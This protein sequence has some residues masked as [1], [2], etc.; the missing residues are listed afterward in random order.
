MLPYN[1]KSCFFNMKICFATFLALLPLATTAALAQEPAVKDSKGFYGTIGLGFS[2]PQDLTASGDSKLGIP[3]NADIKLGGG[4]AGEAG[5]GY[6]FGLVR[7]ELTYIYQ[8]ASL[9][10][11][12]ISTNILGVGLNARNSIHNGNLSSNSVMASAYIDVPTNSRWVP[13]FGGGLGYTNVAWGGFTSTLLGATISQ[14]AGSQGV[15]GYQGKVG[16]SYLASKKTDIFVEGTYQGAAGFSFDSANYD[17]IN[18]WGARLGARY[19]F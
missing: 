19:R 13:Y 12:D 4:F 17:P 18:S 1:I 8:N 14:K 10:S 3:L 9:D 11:V 15:L 2:V 5:L 7:T 6:D 16:L